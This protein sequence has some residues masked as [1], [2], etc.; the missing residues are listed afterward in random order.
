ME[1]TNNF[2]RLSDL[3]PG[4]EAI[5]VKVL[6]HGSFR[7]RLAEMG[8]VR[9]KKV[10]VIKNAPLQDPVEYEIMGYNISLR[11][12]EAELI[13]VISVQDAAAFTRNKH[14][15]GTIDEETLKVSALEKEKSIHVALVGNPNSGKT[16]LFNRISGSHERVGNYGGVTV[17]VKEA[18]VKKNAYAIKLVDLPG[19]YSITEFSPEELYVRVYLTEKMPDIVVNVVDASNLERNLFLTTQLIDMDLKVVIALNMYDELQK[20]GDRLD[21]KYLGKML[22]IPIVPTI[23]TKGE[24]I[25]ELLQKLIDVYEDKDPI[26]RHI[27]I[28]YGSIVEKAIKQIQDVIWQNPAI[29]DKLSSRYLAIKLLEG[30]KTI[31][32]E[33]EKYD[34]YPQIES[35]TRQAIQ[36]LEKEYGDSCETVITQLKYGFIEGA[37]KETYHLSKQKHKEKQQTLDNLFLHKFWG[38]PIFLFFVW[39]MFQSTFSLGKYPTQWLESGINLLGSWLGRI[40]VPGPLCDLL[41]NGIIGGVG[42]V[43]VFF[44]NILILFF[45]VSILEDT[46]YM[47]R[48]AFLMDKLMHKI[49]LHGQSFIPL[50]IGFG[51]NVPAILATR[52]L[53]NRK[54]RILTI[55]I[56]PFMS[57]SARL[58]VYLLLISAIFPKNQALILFSLYSIGIFMAIITALFM[59]RTVF[60]EE[61][62]PFVMELPPYRIPTLKTI[63]I[64][65]WDKSREYLR[66][67]GNIILVASIIIWAMGYFPRH[68]EIDKKYE[69]QI[70]SVQNNT[71][72]S[73]GEKEK[74]VNQLQTTKMAEL[75]QKS[76]I[77]QLGKVVEPAIRPLGFDWKMG[78]GLFT[79]LAAKELVISTMGVLYQV[80][81]SGDN[82]VSLQEKLK[83]EV[84]TAGKLKGEK[85]FTPLVA[86]AFM[87]FILLYVPCVATIAAM[88]K[89]A[90]WQWAVFGVVYNTL[91]AWLMAF[92]IYQIG[93]CIV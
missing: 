49:G 61:E 89:E 71:T 56:I 12:S 70:L 83:N 34:N 65:M 86:F 74:T 40:M 36:S 93:N 19:T 69:E 53:K 64:H 24:G 17:D 48:A 38:Y 13:Q 21:Y 82:S 45:F 41:V 62:S 26:V 11:R 10:K 6:G 15:N 32:S 4:D 87:V 33:L 14:F 3:S 79:G 63:N 60:K 80:D 77:G 42:N 1:E 31:L 54:D 43:L 72:L 30:D 58:P 37:L 81:N 91:V 35:T 5:I 68:P 9:G 73:K 51:C 25:E 92:L 47:S 50:V 39:L 20:K 84:H 7:R 85:V 66:K 29:T 59:K 55:I 16:T 18:E 23:A 57:C 52:T 88:K 78:I 27:H 75:Q 44:P 90:G 22:G 2:K 46:G 28:N 8:F 67:I 76:I